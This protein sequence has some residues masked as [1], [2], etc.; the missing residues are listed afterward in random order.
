MYNL[1]RQAQ[2]FICGQSDFSCWGHVTYYFEQCAMSL[3]RASD[4]ISL[5]PSPRCW[6]HFSVFFKP[7][8]FMFSYHNKSSVMVPEMVIPRPCSGSPLMWHSLGLEQLSP[9][10]ALA[11]ECISTPLNMPCRGQKAAFSRHCHIWVWAKLWQKSC[12]PN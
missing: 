4:I 8:K 12:K 11:S 9:L 7:L 6:Q 1:L 10:D 3:M 2:I 5:N